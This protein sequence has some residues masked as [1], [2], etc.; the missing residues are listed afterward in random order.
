MKML[1]RVLYASIDSTRNDAAQMAPLYVQI[2]GYTATQLNAYTVY[3]HYGL[4]A[5][6]W[7]TNGNTNMNLHTKI[8][9]RT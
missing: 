2:A 8:V 9:E 3:I 5:R 7:I 1:Q 6:C 4:W